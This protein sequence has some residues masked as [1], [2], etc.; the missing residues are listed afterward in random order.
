MTILFRPFPISS[1]EPYDIPFSGDFDGSTGYFSQVLSVAGNRKTGT[2]SFWIKRDT[3]G[4]EEGMYGAG[5]SA[6][7]PSQGLGVIFFGTSG[8]IQTAISGGVKG[9]LRTTATF[10]FSSWAHVVIV[11]DTSNA[12]S[13]ERRRL[14]VDGVRITAFDIET[15]QALNNESFWNDNVT[16]HYIGAVNGG[17]VDRHFQ[18]SIADFISVDGLALAPTEFG[19]DDGG[20]WVPK[21]YTGTFGVAGW[22]LDFADNSDLGKDAAPLT[23]AHT[24]A[25]S[26]TKN[27]TITQSTNT[28]TNP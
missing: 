6:A 12:T 8:K 20:S 7:N 26:F 3:S 16:T 22:H 14:Y 21:E 13:S 9:I 5:N 25:N 1:A 10:A 24:S 27:G 23:G 15:Q 28:P 2:Q 19:E 18:G 11:N 17:S 4:S